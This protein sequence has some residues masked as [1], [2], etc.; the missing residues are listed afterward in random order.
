MHDVQRCAPF[1]IKSTNDEERTFSGV[2]AVYHNIDL[3]Y[4]IIGQGA[5]D[6][7]LPY[8]AKYGVTRDEHGV[9][10]GKIVDAKT[11]PEGLYV[12][13]KVSKTAA[14]DNQMTLLRDGVYN[15][16]SVGQRIK[17][18]Q[19]LPDADSV[20]SYWEGAG[21]SPSQDDM[22]RACYGARLITRAQPYEGSTT[23]APMNERTSIT[24]VK[25]GAAGG[26][27]Y[28]DNLR[29]ALET[30][31]ELVER[32]ADIKSMRADE[33]RE[34]GE[35]ARAL[36]SLLEKSL[37]RLDAVLFVDEK[38][39]VPFKAAPVVDGAWDASAAR[40]RLRAWATSGEGEDAKIDFAKYRRG[41]AWYD[42]AKADDL[43]S[44]KLPHHDIK[45]GK[46][47]TV[48]AGVEAAAAAID[49]A[50]GGAGIPEGDR[51]KVKAHLADHS[52]QWDGKPP[53]DG[54][55]S[56]HVPILRPELADEFN[57]TLAN[58]SLL[59]ITL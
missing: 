47:V 44:Y 12:T 58:L 36:L 53:W 42:S 22:D 9:T 19:Y 29:S 59:G 21:Y 18:Q 55:E 24:S 51:D 33:G 54:G 10:T 34:L 26:F 38:G 6:K 39:A 41:F 15:F 56:K 31:E 48:K 57:A 28:A 20:K 17:A 30:V 7:D 3:G 13:G 11:I 8:F 1:E 50:R 16:L 35:E 5:Y 43:G 4:D 40:K 46:F 32:A 27:R 45:D 25:S 52:R 49:G 14:G 2:L 37:S 23:F